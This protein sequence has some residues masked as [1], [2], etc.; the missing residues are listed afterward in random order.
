M[1]ICKKKWNSS[2]EKTYLQ[3]LTSW[4]LIQFHQENKFKKRH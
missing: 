4:S 1:L 2:E 3:I